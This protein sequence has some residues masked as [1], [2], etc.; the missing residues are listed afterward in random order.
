M[1]CAVGANYCRLGF[2]VHT[3]LGSCFFRLSAS[4]VTL[5]TSLPC[6]RSCAC[7]PVS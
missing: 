1:P 3:L 2:V 5:A 6:T 7:S 4:L